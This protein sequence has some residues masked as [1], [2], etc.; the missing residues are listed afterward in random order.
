MSRGTLGRVIY[1]VRVAKNVE[2]KMICEALGSLYRFEP[3]SNYQYVGF[4]SLEFH[5]FALLYRQLGIETMVSIEQRDTPAEQARV[6]FNRPYGHIAMAWGPSHQRLPEISWRKRSIVWLDYDSH[7]DAAILEDIQLVVSQLVSGS[8]LIVT[9]CCEP[10][11][12][13]FSSNAGAVR[14]AK[15]TNSVG[16][17]RVPEGVK[18][19][20]LNGWGLG[21]TYHRIV[22]NEIEATLSAR[23]APLPTGERFEYTQVFNFRYADGNT[24]MVTFG[25]VVVSKT[26]QAKLAETDFE[27]LSFY[28]PSFE[29]YSIKIPRLTVKEARWLS[30]TIPHDVGDQNGIPGEEVAKYKPIHRYFPEF[31]EVEA[32]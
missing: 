16:K 2:R 23:N 19:K 32:I 29:A 12:V 9:V 22:R 30:Q 14:L 13:D 17:E 4:G 27:H 21:E 7:V 8:C 3:L 6:T 26:D 1:R 11:R 31:L 5:D 20:H 28:R 15:L 25:G 18:G 10:K 24:K